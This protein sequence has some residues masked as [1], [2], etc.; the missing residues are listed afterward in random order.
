M[1]PLFVAHLTTKGCMPPCLDPNASRPCSEQSQDGHRPRVEMDSEYNDTALHASKSR[2][3]TSTLQAQWPPPVRIP[4][5][6]Q[7]GAP[8]KGWLRTIVPSARLQTNAPHTRLPRLSSRFD[9]DEGV[10]LEAVQLSLWWEVLSLAGRAAGPSQAGPRQFSHTNRPPTFSAKFC[11]PSS[12]SPLS[13]S[14]SCESSSTQSVHHSGH[15]HH[16]RLAVQPP[17][18]SECLSVL[19]LL[20]EA[21]RRLSSCR[22]TL[23][24]HDVHCA[25]RCNGCRCAP[26]SPSQHAIDPACRVVELAALTTPNA[27]STPQRG[28]LFTF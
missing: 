14:S 20:F 23:H 3:T 19:A 26:T 21:L 4:Y 6:G 10:G 22:I 1:C 16:D 8:P 12:H 13:P 5:P 2:M 25:L 17:I 15:S 7:I 18:L 11:L 9:G 27:R 28:A 24:S